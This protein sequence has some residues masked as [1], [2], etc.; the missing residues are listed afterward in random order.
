MRCFL[1]FSVFVVLSVLAA[2]G[3]QAASGRIYTETFDGP[4][5]AIM[6]NGV[7]DY[8]VDGAWSAH[9]ADHSLELTNAA[10]KHAVR[11]YTTPT[12]TYPG[13]KMISRTDGA[14]I[15][16]DVRVDAVERSG[17]GIVGGFDRHK[18]DYHLFAVGGDQQVYV[19]HRVGGKARLLMAA[20][21]PAVKIGGINRLKVSGEN[22]DLAF[23]VNGA[24]VM[25]IKS[26]ELAGSGIGIGAFGRGTF[27]FD[28]VNIIE[29]VAV[30]REPA[31]PRRSVDSPSIYTFPR[32]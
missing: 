12:L 26:A 23:E 8:G 13:S 20:K 29:P 7:V 16:V 9:I 31:R 2:G 4:D 17:A 3:A 27:A 19:M 11:Y 14:T 1:N 6:L 25:V 5:D 32:R 21:N 24:L 18:K 22:G 10:D 28:T 15:E 30:Y